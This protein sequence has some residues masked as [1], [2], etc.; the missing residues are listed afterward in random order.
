[1]RAPAPPARPVPADAPVVAAAPATAPEKSAGGPPPPAPARQAA[2]PRKESGPGAKRAPVESRP[3]APAAEPGY[4]SFAVSPWGEVYVDGRK[5]GVS[6][7][8]LEAE[9]APGRHTIEIRNTTFPARTETIE[10]KPGARIKIRHRFRGG[11]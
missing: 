3:V 2:A 7:P 4:I 9:V 5:L 1:E 10:V 11:P 6:P 8:L